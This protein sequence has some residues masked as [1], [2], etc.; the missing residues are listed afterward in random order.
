[1]AAKSFADLG[2]WA[3]PITRKP[4][5][6]EDGEEYPNGNPT[7]VIRSLACRWQGVGVT[8]DTG[9]Y[10]VDNALYLLNNT[11]PVSVIAT[12]ARYVGL[13]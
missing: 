1:M 2:F 4:W 9:V 8:L 5:T 6:G 11:E 7:P 3:G 12:T 10:V 13:N